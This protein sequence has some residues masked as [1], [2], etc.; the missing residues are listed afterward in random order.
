MRKEGDPM[1][2]RVRNVVG[3]TV[4]AAAVL[5]TPLAGASAAAA[6]VAVP[7]AQRQVGLVNVAFRNT[8]ITVPINAAAN[9]CGLAVNVLTANL[10]SNNGTTTCTNHQ[11]QTVT[12]TQV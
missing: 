1:L 6:P 8:S 12:I 10:L 5:V 11:G 7:E 3:A 4:L 9:I 2:K